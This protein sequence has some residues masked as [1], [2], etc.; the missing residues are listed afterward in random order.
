MI[1]ISKFDDQKTVECVVIIPIL[2]PKC[3]YIRIGIFSID[4]NFYDNWDLLEPVTDK[5]VRRMG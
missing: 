4:I 1:N 2:G 5:N 3:W